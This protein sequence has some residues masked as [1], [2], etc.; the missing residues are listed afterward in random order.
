MTAAAPAGEGL[1]V[2]TRDPNS[3]SPA[4]GA[5]L[6]EAIRMLAAFAGLGAG[7]LSFGISSTLLASAGS[8]GSWAGVLASAAWGIALTAWAVQQLRFR[9][10]AWSGAVVR[11]LP[12]SALA[13]LAAVVYGLWWTPSLERALDLAAIS[14]L[15]LDLVLAGSAGW[16]ARKG[17]LDSGPPVGAPAAGRL[18]PALLAAALAVAAITTPGLAATTAGQHAVPHGQHGSPDIQGPAGHGH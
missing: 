15:A 10:P 7:T 11:L 12:V 17:L 4:P 9:T 13:H 6:P 3:I 8:P 18:L 5:L 14:A 16:L 2:P 1:T